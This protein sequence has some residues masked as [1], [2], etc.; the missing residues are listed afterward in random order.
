[1]RLST[2]ASIELVHETKPQSY[3][4]FN[5]LGCLPDGIKLEHLKLICPHQQD[6]EDSVEF[7]RDLNFL[8][9]SKDKILLTNHLIE[10]VSDTYEIDS[11]KELFTKIC[12]F[13]TDFLRTLYEYN[14]AIVW[15]KPK[16]PMKLDR[17]FRLS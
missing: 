3:E 5:L 14:D 1:M 8:S 11:K 9:K 17:T 2:E 4:L 12:K 7:F 15:D 10:F 16:E 6:V 13:Y